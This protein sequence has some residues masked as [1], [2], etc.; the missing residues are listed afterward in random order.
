MPI[1]SLYSDEIRLAM[2]TDEG[3]KEKM[4]GKTKYNFRYYTMPT[5]IFARCYEI[6][7]RNELGISN[8]L[9]NASG[10]IYPDSAELKT[11][12]SEYFGSLFKREERVT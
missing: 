8:S 3:L 2:D 6:Y 4:N 9:I 11:K 5:E 7:C 10:S 12:I 1:M